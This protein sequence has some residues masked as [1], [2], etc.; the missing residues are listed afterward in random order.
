MYEATTLREHSFAQTSPV[1]CADKNCCDD[2]T[3]MPEYFQQ[4]LAYESA[5]TFQPYTFASSGFAPDAIV[6]NLGT[7]K[8]SSSLSVSF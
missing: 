7:S 3:T 5:E 8:R 1:V 2:G 4:R 6:I